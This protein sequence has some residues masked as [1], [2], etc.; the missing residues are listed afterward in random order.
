MQA[1]IELA[2]KHDDFSGVEK[3]LERALNPFVAV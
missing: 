1:A 2:E 3:L